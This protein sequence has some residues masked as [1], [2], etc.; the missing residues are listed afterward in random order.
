VADDQTI[1]RTIRIEATPEIVFG[2]LTDPAL[3][4]QWMGLGAE[5]DARPGGIYRFAMARQGIFV[6]GE[7]VE[8]ERP[9][10]LV[11]TWGWEGSD[12]LVPPGSTRVEFTLRADRGATL[13]TL[14]HSGLPAGHDAFH[15]MG[16][17][18]YL[19]RLAEIAAGRDPGPDRVD[20][21][22][23]AMVAALPPQVARSE[24]QAS[25]GHQDSE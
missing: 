25:E 5:V 10:R 1:E 17:E 14:R 15:A 3:I 2:C 16:W 4:P 18:H 20:G 19:P 7:F 9:H 24:P 6:R 13:L 12:R 8:V 21:R 23:G 22:V 11:F